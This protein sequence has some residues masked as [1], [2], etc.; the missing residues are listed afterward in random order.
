M[1]E[2]LEVPR[3]EVL[4]TCRITPRPAYDLTATFYRHAMARLSHAFSQ[5]KTLHGQTNVLFATKFK[6]QTKNYAFLPIF[7]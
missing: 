2:E 1:E 5:R 6:N 4:R 3:L 7:A